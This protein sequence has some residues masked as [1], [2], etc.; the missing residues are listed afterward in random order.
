[1]TEKQ[2]I[3][4]EVEAKSNMSEEDQ[5]NLLA[6]FKKGM[7]EKFGVQILEQYDFVISATL[8]KD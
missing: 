4:I 8:L 6:G 7:V 5:Q 3:K 2:K 1:M